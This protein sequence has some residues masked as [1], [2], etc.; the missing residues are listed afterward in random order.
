MSGHEHGARWIPA[1]CDVSIRP[2][3][4]YHQREDTLVKSPETLFDLYLKST[5]RNSLLL[6]N[7]PPDRRGRIAVPD[8][9]SLMGFRRL[10]ENAF[11]HDLARGAAAA[12]S[13]LWSNNPHFGASSAVDGNP[14]SYWAGGDTGQGASL[15]I[16]LRAQEVIACAVLGE[17]ISLGQRVS[18]FHLEIPEGNRWRTV[19]SGST[20]GN[21]RILLFPPVR[22]RK[23]RLLITG[24]RGTP[25]ISSFELYH[26]ASQQ[27]NRKGAE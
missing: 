18:S 26:D 23:V 5:G 20:I 27:R 16:T 8:S 22:T 12:T 25:L 15:A 6:L 9:I 17:P 1:E 13:S 2:G 7:I 21:K 10:R 11:A 14:D 3:W 24:S 19:A 4:F